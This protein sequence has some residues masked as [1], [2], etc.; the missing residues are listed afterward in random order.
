MPCGISDKQVTSL[1]KLLGRT[2]DMA[3]V[4]E[5]YAEEFAAVFGAEIKN[6]SIA[7]VLQ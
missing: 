6:G 3:E 2:A 7:P 5:M 1:S 4:K